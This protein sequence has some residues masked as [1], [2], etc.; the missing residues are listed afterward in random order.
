MNQY[1]LFFNKGFIRTVKATSTFFMDLGAEYCVANT[2]FAGWDK[3][4]QLGILWFINIFVD[5]L[6]FSPLT[7]DNIQT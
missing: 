2:S 1:R 3:R 5:H 7:N 4:I 6:F